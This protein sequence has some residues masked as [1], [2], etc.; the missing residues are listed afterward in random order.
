MT[1]YLPQSNKELCFAVIDVTEVSREEFG[2]DNVK[3][4]QVK[5]VD[6]KKC[7]KFVPKS[8][9]LTNPAEH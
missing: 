4:H 6:C 9:G 1:D 3:G 8:Q 5:C 2:N 7:N